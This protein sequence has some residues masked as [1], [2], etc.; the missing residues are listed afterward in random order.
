MKHKKIKAKKIDKESIPDGS[1]LREDIMEKIGTIYPLAKSCHD[2]IAKPDSTLDEWLLS[3]EEDT[4][5]MIAEYSPKDKNDKQLEEEMFMIAQ[6]I[7]AFQKGH[8]FKPV[9]WKEIY[10]TLSKLNLAASVALFV[11]MGA[12]ESHRDPTKHKWDP[13][14]GSIQLAPGVEIVEK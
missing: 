5:R 3:L 6:F 12:M 9:H 1:V 2:M 14:S 13:L 8:L 4:I 11:K 7:T 10:T